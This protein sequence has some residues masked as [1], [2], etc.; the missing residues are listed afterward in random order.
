VEST[1]DRPGQNWKESE[2]VGGTSVGK[3]RG[4]EF[5]L[6]FGC[7]CAHKHVIHEP[8]KHGHIG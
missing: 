8:E 4:E 5:V 3:E 2:P 7:V 1:E 6:W